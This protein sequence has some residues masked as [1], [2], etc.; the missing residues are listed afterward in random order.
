[1]TC[2]FVITVI[3][4]I[5]SNKYMIG[6]S[7]IVTQKESSY[8]PVGRPSTTK[9]AHLYVNILLRFLGLLAVAHVVCSTVHG[10]CC[11]DS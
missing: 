2:L 1:V 8:R 5:V 11:L 4:R 3:I 6:L 10:S 7:P 9:L